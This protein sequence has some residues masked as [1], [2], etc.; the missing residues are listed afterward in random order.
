M[1]RRNWN[2]FLENHPILHNGNKLFSFSS[3]MYVTVVVCSE[4]VALVALFTSGF[5]FRVHYVCAHGCK[6]GREHP[7]DVIHI[8]TACFPL[9]H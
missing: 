9:S 4:S 8:H 1:H 2:I 3:E 6:C 7:L 5:L